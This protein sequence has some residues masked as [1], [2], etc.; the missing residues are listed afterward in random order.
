M[1][2]FVA[3]IRRAVDGLSDNTP[4]MRLKVYEKARGAVRRQLEAMNPRPS[5]E[6]IKRQL[7]KLEA[8][9]GSVES[10]HAE[11]LPSE[12]VAEAP[13]EEIP[14]AEPV[15]VAEPEPV[16]A[17]PQ[18]D[19]PA[20]AEPYEPEPA[21][22]EQAEATE[23]WA[24]PSPV[25][26]QPVEEPPVEPEPVE[27]EAAEP[28][29]VEHG[30]EER[31]WPEEEAQAAPEDQGHDQQPEEHQP[32]AAEAHVEP[33]WHVEAE[34]AE[35]YVPSWHEPEPVVEE[36]P[37]EE[38]AHS[39]ESLDTESR[40]TDV[41][42]EETVHPVH[43]E[44]DVEAAPVAEARMPAADAQWNWDEAVP[45][46]T[47]V[48]GGAQQGEQ[49]AAPEDLAWDWPGDKAAEP[50]DKE[51]K[52]AASSEWSDLE[53]LIG[54]DRKPEPGKQASM[55]EAG[56]SD[57]AASPVAETAAARNGPQRSFRAEPRKSRFNL[58]A[59]IALLAIL[60]VFGGAG[61]AY[62]FNR[63]AVNDWV[64]DLIASVSTP[65]T[66][67]AGTQETTPES[68]SG[69]ERSLPASSTSSETEG[70]TAESPTELAAATGGQADGGKFTQRLLPDGTE[71][72]EGPAASPD[73]STAE[74]G[75]S[76]A[77]QTQETAALATGDNAASDP[78][79]ADA[80]TAS[81]EGAAQTP[82][83]A[84]TAET[85]TQTSGGGEQP[86]IGVAQ[87]MFLYEERLGQTGPTAIDGTV[88]WTTA[89]ESPGGDARPE[90]VVRAQVNVPSNGLTALITFR[91][92]S[93]QSLP[94]SHLV[95]VVFSLPPSFEGGGIDSVQR[96]ALKQTEQDRGDALIAVPAKITEDFHMIAL[97]DFPEAI[98]KN[99]ELL[100]TRNWIDIP[101]TYRNG[102]RA[103]ITLD[104]GASGA[105]AFDTA[106]RAWA[107]LGAADSQ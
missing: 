93:D 38:G 89:E 44:G 10:E 22:E 53:D 37:V 88:V 79:G 4:E 92:N 57:A 50:G 90:P 26:E 91:R 5:D 60:V 13:F 42:P 9:I 99:T 40:E 104:K 48:E 69:G 19:E 7:D 49:A 71:V 17:E 29:P 63:D 77:P 8:A 100:R 78:A 75:K 68:T 73:G 101:I 62:W 36:P 87:K 33:S 95:E 107:A 83:D 54:Y 16:E 96:V 82:G 94:A 81:T 52:P 6:L 65:A 12:D 64:G 14:E 102:R 66:E 106:M 32:V 34:P 47:P 61:A 46:V 2:D 30:Q 35:A 72:D 20:E 41:Q 58:G 11:A 51:G 97:N 59:L 56:L 74:E 31:R 105:E 55:D 23:Q 15:A 43:Y 85:G 70:G 39:A 76:V 24:E 86:T 80:G 103:L 28:E 3:V 27:P 25:A 1:A 98:A 45:A 21:A 84:A 67:T 18:R